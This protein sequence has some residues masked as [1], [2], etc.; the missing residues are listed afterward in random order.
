MEEPGAGGQDPDV[1]EPEHPP[2]LENQTPVSV[3]SIYNSGGF[4]IIAR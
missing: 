1:W 3:L 4:P 2:V